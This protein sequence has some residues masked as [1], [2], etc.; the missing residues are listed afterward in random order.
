MTTDGFTT[1]LWFNGQ[2][3]EAA[4]HYTSIADEYAAAR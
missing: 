4:N 3:E 2:D 1:C